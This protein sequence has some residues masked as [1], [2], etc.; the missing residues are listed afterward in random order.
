MLAYRHQFHAGNFADVFKHVLLTRML[1]ALGRKEKPFCYSETHAGIGFYDLEHAWTQKLGE[2][3]SGVERVWSRRDVPALLEPYTQALSAENPSG[4]LR[5]YPGSPRIARRFLR[6][7][8]RAELAELNG[9]DYETLMRVFA[10]DRQ[11]RVHHMDGYQA[12]KAFLPPRERRG[13][14]LVDSSFDRAREYDRLADAL[15]G[16]HQRWATGVYALW[17]PLMEPY[18]VRGFE[19]RIAT[20][21]IRKVL[22]LELSVLPEGWTDSLRGCAMLIVNPPFGLDRE[23]AQLLPWL[24]RVLA[25][26]GCGGSRVD[27]LVPE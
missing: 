17:Y 27:W 21:G 18:A 26:A 10:G 15:K 5:W 24:A 12:L 7:E 19:R 23:A 4:T 1:L 14:V 22:K 9:H 16:A 25:E 20:S 3:H 6:T 8:D 2:Y 13:L 11:V